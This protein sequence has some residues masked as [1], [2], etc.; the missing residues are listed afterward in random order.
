MLRSAP[1]RRPIAVATHRGSHG[2]QM[3]TAPT[4]EASAASLHT[5]DRNAPCCR[6]IGRPSG[7]IQ[8][9]CAPTG[10]QHVTEREGWVPGC[11]KMLLRRL[12]DV[13][14]ATHRVGTQPGTHDLL[15]PPPADGL[16]HLARRRLLRSTALALP[17]PCCAVTVYS[18]L[19]CPWWVHQGRLI[20]LVASQ[21][22]TRPSAARLLQSQLH[23]RL[24]SFSR[25]WAPPFCLLAH[26]LPALSQVLR[27]PAAVGQGAHSHAGRAG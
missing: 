20:T 16:C 2:C 17:P 6:T 5:F 19:A 26:L 7:K 13:L 1:P 15:A 27:G 4:W 8:H 10:H 14:E 21:H 18:D 9:T 25:P 22:S 3:P 23:A 11:S 24:F 12:P